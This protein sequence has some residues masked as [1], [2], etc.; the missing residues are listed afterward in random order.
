MSAAMALRHVRTHV[1]VLLSQGSGLLLFALL[2]FGT[3]TSAA[4]LSPAAVL[5]LLAAGVFGLIGYLAFYHAVSLGSPGL[6]SAI[7]STYGG[8]AALLSVL[9]LAERLSAVG[10]AGIVLAVVGITVAVARPRTTTASAGEQTRRLSKPTLAATLALV[11]ALGY[12]V[13]G[14][15]I[16]EYSRQTGWLLPGVIA[17]GASVAVLASTLPLLRGR[18][19]WRRLSGSSLA[20]IVTAGL[21][22]AGALLAYSRG[23]Q[24]GQLA[25]TAAVSSVYPIIPLAIGV[26]V[27]GERISR[28]QVT[29]ILIIITGLV[30][31]ALALPARPAVGGA[32]KPRGRIPTA[33]RVASSMY[34]PYFRFTTAVFPGR[35]CSTGQPRF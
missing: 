33:R 24:T 5:G 12:G 18:N 19:D 21:A 2:A 20:W 4:S 7:S 22:D 35:R 29:G 34:A 23:T 27:L 17:H 13:G 11:S 28:G 14:F 30:L 16:G 3:R 6:M 32:R 8:V 26:L 9:L 10:A 15:I 25:I 31:L 1:V